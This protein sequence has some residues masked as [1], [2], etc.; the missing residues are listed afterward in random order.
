[1]F[2]SIIIKFLHEFI[3]NLVAVANTRTGQ[4]SFGRKIIKDEQRKII[5]DENRTNAGS[6]D[7]ESCVKTRTGR[8]AD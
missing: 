4:T 7:T 2:V 3:W 1:M 6:P 5:K 8:Y